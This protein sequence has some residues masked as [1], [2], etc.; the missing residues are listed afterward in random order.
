MT[1]PRI[2]PEI[3]TIILA[4]MDAWNLTLLCRASRAFY[5]QAQC[6][7][8]HSVDLLVGPAPSRNTRTS[9]SAPIHLHCASR[10][11]SHSI[12]H[13]PRKSGRALAK[14]INL[15]DLRVV[16]EVSATGERQS[17]I[18][19]WM[20]NDCSF[21]LT[22]FENL[23]FNDRWIVDFWKKQTE[24]QVLVMNH[25][26]G[27]FKDPQLLPDLI[28]V[29]TSQLSNLPEGRA[30]QRIE[31]YFQRELL[32]LAQYKRTLTTLNLVRDW[33][34][35]Q[36]SIGDAISAVAE[37]VSHLVHFGIIE[38]RK[39]SY[40][41][42][43]EL[44]SET[45]LRRFAKLET[46]TL[47]MLN[48]EC[49]AVDDAM[50]DMDAPAGVYGLGHAMMMA[51]PTLRR[52]AICAEADDALTSVLTRSRGGEIHAEAG[53]TFDFETIRQEAPGQPRVAFHAFEAAQCWSDV[54]PSVEPDLVSPLLQGTFMDP[55]RPS[56][57]EV[58][59]F[60]AGR[61]ARQ[62]NGFAD[63][64]KKWELRDG[65]VGRRRL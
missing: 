13:T 40:I 38:R 42:P 48:V 1:F 22:R 59:Y 33:V 41:L 12:H 6:I 65:N 28:A 14:C 27:C 47:H 58:F 25:N 10:A 8:Y 64:R 15:K 16:G 35:L 20:I 52:A 46:I 19:G 18:H 39:D 24:I 56:E 4:D 55:D 44:T 2:P 49:F 21:R 45:T 54:K 34:D 60:A 5:A 17:C 51:C 26:L 50:Y 53:T 62:R 43:T 11:R 36:F 57:E 37:L 9:L 61:L 63:R 23:Y 31:T 3:W 30:L 29:G 7:L 32:P